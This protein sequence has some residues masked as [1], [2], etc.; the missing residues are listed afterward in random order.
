MKSIKNTILIPSTLL[1]PVALFKKLA[2]CKYC[3]IEKHET[4]S[5]QSF[6]NRYEIAAPN[7]IQALSIPVI[8]I[9]GNHTRT[10]EVEIDYSED[11]IGQHLKSIETAYQ[12]SPFYMYYI[13]YIAEEFNKKH[14]K[15]WKL[16]ENLFKLMLKWL[17]IDCKID[18]TT[19]YIKEYNN[20]IDL[21]T[22]LHPKK[23]WHKVEQDSYPQCFDERY[24]F[25]P[26]LSI[27]DL[28]FNLGP[29]SSLFLK[30]K[31]K[32]NV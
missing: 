18:F 21:R 24:G 22:V 17:N 32:Y 7:K 8:K 11:W 25:R 2:Q 6:R 29:E 10:D 19:Q 13:D 26:G 27:L 9:N 31:L 16:N 3:I 5:K 15:L 20:L 28:L 12:S 14:K 30:N 23:D 4:Y 1:G